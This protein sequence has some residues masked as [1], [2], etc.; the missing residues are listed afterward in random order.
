MFFSADPGNPDTNSHFYTDVEMFT[1]GSTDP[2]QTSYLSGWTSD[3]IAQ[4][5]NSWKS[6][7]YE[8]YNSPDYDK[9]FAQYL[10]ETDPDKRAALVI[11]LNDMLVSDVVVIPLVARKLV[12]G[13]SKLL[14]GNNY[15]P[16]ESDLYDIASWTKSG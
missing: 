5:S 10:K 1:N 7:N 14:Q 9:L 11:Q 12:G 3:Q 4:K 15:S 16:W 8:R 2:D 6:N 13:K